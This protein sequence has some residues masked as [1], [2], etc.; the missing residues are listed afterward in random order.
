MLA[1]RYAWRGVLL[2]LAA[3]LLIWMMWL[4]GSSEPFGH[5]VHQRKNYQ[6]YQALH[7]EAL[8]PVKLFVRLNLN[9]VCT[10]HVTNDYQ[11]A[12]VALSGVIVAFFTGTLWW[13]T[14]GMVRLAR[15]QRTDVKESLRIA[16]QSA[17]AAIDQANISRLTTAANVMVDH[18]E[19]EVVLATGRVFEGMSFCVVLANNGL[20]S[21]REMKSAASVAVLGDAKDFSYVFP[22][23][24]EKTDSIVIGREARINTSGININADHTIAVM[25]GRA[26]LFLFGWAEYDD[27]FPDTQRHRVEYCFKVRLIGHLAEG[28]CES[29]FELYGPNNRHYDIPRPP[30]PGKGEGAHG[31]PIA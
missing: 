21:T 2:V 10:V 19:A 12:V 27:I 15:D 4:V 9:A 7:K 3:V 30:P 31:A 17:Q 13:V 29:S 22:G 14:L 5:C 1:R 23:L 24:N 28:K 16:A 20:S 25:Q 11:G 26:H 18:A 8:L 6:A